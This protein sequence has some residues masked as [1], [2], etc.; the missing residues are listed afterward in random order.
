MTS[1]TSADETS[2][3]RVRRGFF[4]F[5]VGET[6]DVRQAGGNVFVSSTDL[7]LIQGGGNFLASG[8]D[9]SIREGGGGIIVAGRDVTIEEGGSALLMAR[10]ATVSNGFVG[11]VLSR[12]VSVEGDARVLATPK[13]AAAFGA[14]AAVTLLLGHSLLRALGGLLRSSK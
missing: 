6:V 14:A 1:D 5:V 3:V 9:L 13:E 12:S 11:A 4:P 2:H 10:S 7:T 8:R